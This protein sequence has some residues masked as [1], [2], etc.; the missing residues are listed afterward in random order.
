MTRHGREGGTGRTKLG[1]LALLGALL[2]AGCTEV[3]WWD[4]RGSWNGGATL[5]GEAETQRAGGLSDPEAGSSE[6]RI[7]LCRLSALHLGLTFVPIERGRPA[8]IEVR[9]SRPLCEEGRTGITGGA[10][11]VWEN[12][13]GDPNVLAAVRSE[14]WTVTG[15]IH[16]TGHVDRG[17]PDL[18]AGE[19]ANTERVDG[20]F[21][22]TATHVDG[23]V[24]RIEGGTFELTVV[25]S[26]VKLSLS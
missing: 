21:S 23:S 14:S 6:E 9:T 3:T 16:V 22:L 25:A 11:M 17:L 10:V 2:T 13:G 19:S 24:I 12:P 15:E 20:T 26:R 7:R 8:A 1:G 4:A 18:D 5:P